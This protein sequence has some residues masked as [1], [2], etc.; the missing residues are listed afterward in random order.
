MAKWVLHAENEKEKIKA[1]NQD[2]RC[3]RRGRF[4]ELDLM[5]GIPPQAV[6]GKYARGRI[7]VV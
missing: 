7:H 4:N 2:G 5:L 6:C 3:T 1:K